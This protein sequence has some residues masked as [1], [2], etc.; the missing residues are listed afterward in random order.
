MTYEVF[1]EETAMTCFVFFVCQV[2][3]SYS[4]TEGSQVSLWVARSVVLRETE[5][6]DVLEAKMSDP[7]RERGAR[8][9]FDHAIHVGSIAH[10]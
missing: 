10:W 7:I 1:Y 5:S 4:E 3:S 6:P 8:G 9:F 2:R